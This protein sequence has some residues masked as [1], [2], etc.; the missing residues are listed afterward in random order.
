MVEL[1]LLEGDVPSPDSIRRQW[2]TL[3]GSAELNG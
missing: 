2:T 1:M 3:L